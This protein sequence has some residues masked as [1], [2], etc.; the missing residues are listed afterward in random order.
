[1]T[2]Y[3]PPKKNTA[4]ILYIGL[5]DR[6]DPGAFKAAPTLAAGD[7]KVSID[8]GTL[9]NLTTLPTVTPASG[10]MVKVSLSASEMNGDNVTLVMSDAAGGEWCDVIVNLQTAVNQIDDLSSRL[11]AALVSGRIDSS[12]GAMATDTI[13]SG[14]LATTAVNEI[15][16]GLLDKTDG[17]E[18]GLTMRQ[19]LRLAAAVLFGK[20]SGLATTTAVY[21][22]TNDSKNRISATVDASG[23]RSAVTR[24]AS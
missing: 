16:D 17:V 6:A 10:K 24:D 4:L 9:A 8:G 14:A 21:R 20:A 23:N 5:P 22:D 13:T 15:A 3:V 11:P 2:T 1:V 12:V 18:S 7:A 19:W